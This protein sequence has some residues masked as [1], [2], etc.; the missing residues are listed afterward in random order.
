MMPDY[1]SLNPQSLAI[2]PLSKGMITNIPTQMIPPGGGMNVLNFDVETIGLRTC[3]QWKPF[4]NPPDFARVPLEPGEYITDV[5]PFYMIGGGRQIVTLTSRRLFKTTDGKTW[6]AVQKA[7]TPPTDF[8]FNTTKPFVIQW[9]ASVT[10]LFFVDGTTTTGIMVYDG[11]TLRREDPKDE[12][13]TTVFNGAVSIAFISG[14]L[15]VGNTGEAGGQQ[16][17]RWSS[18][19]PGNQF[20]FSQLDFVDLTQLRGVVQKVTHYEEYPII[21][22]DDG[23]YFGQPYGYDAEFAAAWIFRPLESGGNSIIGPRAFSR[24]LG[25]IAF[26]GRDDFFYINALKRTEKGDFTIESMKCPILRE[27]IRSI[28]IVKTNTIMTYDSHHKRLIVGMGNNPGLPSVNR[29]CA[30]HPDTNAWS[31]FTMPLPELTSL[32][33]ISTAV[34]RRWADVNLLTTWGDYIAGTNGSWYSELSGFSAA[35]LL[36]TSA[37]GIMYVMLNNLGITRLVVGTEEVPQT[38]TAIFE[39]GDLDLDVPDN[40]KVAFKLAARIGNTEY[41]RTVP[42]EFEVFGSSTK[43]RQ[44][45]RLGLVRIDPDEDEEEIHFRLSGTNLRFRLEFRSNNPDLTPFVLEELTI[46]IRGG[47]QQVVRNTSREE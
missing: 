42:I 27:T 24:V 28:D 38:F 4:Q 1:N 43:G 39:T 30:Y 8:T 23:V 33:D 5:I 22:T 29:Y 7:G 45:K 34:A 13:N 40:N 20:S 6:D 31:M 16:R 35:K 26:A 19:I 25:G 32:Q 44:W 14:R 47:G 18:A 15:V 46:R 41:T 9:A 36:G 37:D 17:V 3:S 11:Y 21:F 12:N 2:R 10:E